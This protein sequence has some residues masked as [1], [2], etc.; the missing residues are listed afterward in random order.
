M[1]KWEYK[2]VYKLEGPADE[3]KIN[4]ITAMLNELGK[5]GWELICIEKPLLY[6]KREL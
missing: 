5:E 1:K 4:K 3:V 6:F 2:V